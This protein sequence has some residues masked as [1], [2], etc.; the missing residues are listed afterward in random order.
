MRNNSSI[1]ISDLTEIS[2]EIKDLQINVYID[3]P[4]YI[5]GFCVNFR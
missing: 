4:R 3:L 5:I 2:T 1:F